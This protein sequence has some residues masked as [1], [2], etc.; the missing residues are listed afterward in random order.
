MY[1]RLLLY[2][3]YL[4]VCSVPCY[5][6]Y[7]VSVVFLFVQECFDYVVF[8][9]PSALVD[10]SSFEK[11]RVIVIIDIVLNTYIAFK[12]VAI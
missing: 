4:C 8:C 5:F 7:Y 12:W 1:L 9:I 3:L 6:Y 2:S 11:G 10:Y